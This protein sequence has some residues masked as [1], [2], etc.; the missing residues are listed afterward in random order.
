MAG[1]AQAGAGVPAGA[2]GGLAG[3]GGRGLS[4]RV[5]TTIDPTLTITDLV[6]TTDLAPITDRVLAATGPAPTHLPRLSGRSSER[7][8]A[9][10][11]KD[12]PGEAAFE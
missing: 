4:Y 7:S 8:L 2:G 12:R 1:A 5:P 6:H 10:L 3:D 9:R 11:L